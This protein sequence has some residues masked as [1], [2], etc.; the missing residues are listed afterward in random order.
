MRIYFA[1][2]GESQANLL[3]EISNRG[4]QHGLT[5]QGRQQALTLAQHLQGW[6]ITRIYSSPLL[7][8][9][10]TSVIL[11]GQLHL[12]YEVTTALREYD[13]GILEGRSDQEA[14]QA[15]Q[16]LFDAWVLRRRWDERIP[17][18][19][20]FYDLRARFEPFMAG[21]LERHAQTDADVLC[22]SHG[23][24][25]WMM[26]PLVLKNVNTE[27]ISRYGFEYTSCIVAELRPQGLFCVEWNGQPVC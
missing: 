27:L 14:W 26:L 20:S 25:Y 24:L 23:G 16:E 13:C 18:G 12:D 10:E 8:A 19:E 15:W 3:H 17:G 6:P 5:Q 1:R 22:V 4:L 9:I 21:L 7:R 11:A 2:H